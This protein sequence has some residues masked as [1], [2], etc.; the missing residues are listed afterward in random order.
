MSTTRITTWRRIVAEQEAWLAERG[1]NLEGYLAF[2]PR[3][4][5][6]NIKDIYEADMA[7]LVRVR[8]RLASL[9]RPTDAQRQAAQR[10]P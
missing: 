10:Q 5:P 4:T 2:Y 7:A 9:E 6:E 1:G 3:R 8:G